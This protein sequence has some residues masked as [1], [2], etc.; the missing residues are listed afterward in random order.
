MQLV[1]NVLQ[2]KERE[3]AI[4]RAESLPFLVLDEEQ[5]KDVK[6]IAKGVYSPLTGFLKRDDFERVVKE[7]CLVSGEVW[8]IP[9]VLNI[10]KQEAA[11]LEKT[12]EKTQEK[13]L[14]L[15]DEKGEVV[16][17]FKDSSLSERLAQQARAT[18]EESFSL[19]QVL[20]REI[21]LTES[22]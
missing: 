19:K 14:A 17:L 8:P 2:G 9:I 1:D 12:Q 10:S 15:K 3:E 21:K 6:N 4:K 16:A 5:V 13:V 22:V 20:S 7:M 18:L 11:E